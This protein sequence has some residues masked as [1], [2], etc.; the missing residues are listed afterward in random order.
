[1]EAGIIKSEKLF[2]EAD[3]KSLQVENDSSVYEKDS[4]RKMP[5]DIPA[6]MYVNYACLF[7]ELS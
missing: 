3:S 1:M 6:E 5:I 4:E 2:A 7:V